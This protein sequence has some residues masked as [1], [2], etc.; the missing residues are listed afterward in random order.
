MSLVTIISKLFKPKEKI[1]KGKTITQLVL[2]Y[3]IYEGD[4]ANPFCIRVYSMDKNHS[5]PRSTDLYN[6][7]IQ[8]YDSNF[9]IIRYEHFLPEA[10]KTLKERFS[11]YKSQQANKFYSTIFFFSIFSFM[12]SIL[13]LNVSGTFVPNLSKS[14]TASKNSFSSIF[15]SP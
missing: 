5:F 13:L 9:E 6:Y 1:S 4:K 3:S 12:K 8:T 2:S 11:A 7:I 15:I 14:E 10:E